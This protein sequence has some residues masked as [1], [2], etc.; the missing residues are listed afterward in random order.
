M[1]LGP[2]IAEANN[3]YAYDRVELMTDYAHAY[4]MSACSNDWKS[5]FSWGK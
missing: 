1:S 3:D 5:L 4:T 2:A